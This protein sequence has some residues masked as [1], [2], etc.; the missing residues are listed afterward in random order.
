MEDVED[1][2]DDDDSYGSF[3]QQLL[4]ELL[5]GSVLSAWEYGS[6]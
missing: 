4:I 6:K 5:S 3:T 2:N 1:D